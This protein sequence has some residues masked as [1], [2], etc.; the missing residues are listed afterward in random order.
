MRARFAALLASL[1]LAACAAEQ[2]PSTAQLPPAFYGT[3]VDNDTGAINEASYALGSP[4]RTRNDPIEAIRAVVAVEYLAGELNTN[5]R[6]GSL[7]AMTKMQMLEARK[8][9]RQ[10]LGIPQ[11]APSQAVVNALLW[12]MWQMQSNN[13]PGVMQAL[14]V[15][16]FSKGA[17]PTLQ[18]LENLPVPASARVAT[19]NAERGEFR[20]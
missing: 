8:D 9:L 18:L 15:P 19:A 2:I 13:Q 7:S 6:W 1:P 17:Q 14:S 5:P 20:F 16:L 12:V 4:A 10:E 11:N 3:L